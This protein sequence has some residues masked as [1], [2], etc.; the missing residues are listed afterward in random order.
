MIS[1]SQ[2]KEEKLDP[3][4]FKWELYLK[5][6][7]TASIVDKAAGIIN[8]IAPDARGYLVVKFYCCK[9][10]LEKCIQLLSNYYEVLNIEIEKD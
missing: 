10:D 5:S 1:F 4:H 3:N 8:R 7:D 6:K 9:P 2:W